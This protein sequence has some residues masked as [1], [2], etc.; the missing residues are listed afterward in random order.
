MTPI[1]GLP[2]FL[3]VGYVDDIPIDYYDSDLRKVIPRQRW[4]AECQGPEYWE[5]QTQILRSSEHIG[6]TNI[7][8]ALNHTNQSGGIHTVQIM[9]GC[10]LQDDGKSNGF[11]QEGWDGQD[12]ISFDKEH[13]VWVTPV[14]WGL[15]TKNKWDQDKARNL[16]RKAYLERTCIEWLK[17]YLKQGKRELKP[18]APQMFLTVDTASATDSAQLSCLVTG[19][20][21]RDIEVVLLK[22]DR[23]IGETYSTGILPNHN[24]TYQFRRWAV[25]NL[26]DRA[27]YSCQYEHSSEGLETRQLVEAFQLSPR[28]LQGTNDHLN[29]GIVAAV[30]VLI[31][32][33]VGMVVWRRRGKTAGQD[34]PLTGGKKKSIYNLANSTD[35]GESPTISFSLA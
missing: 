1:S 29:I 4:M 17:T 24:G 25:I 30:L 27:T 14:S 26:E 10:E 23:P 5:Q 31:G 34:L 18:I 21:P 8:T 32:I 15:I 12:Y 22:N 19:F 11:H 6:L 16:Q 9:H 7:Q 2:E 13:M 35:S 3:A 28:S 20:Y 33:V